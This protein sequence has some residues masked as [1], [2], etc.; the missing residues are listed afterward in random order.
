MKRERISLKSLPKKMQ[1]LSIINYTLSG[2]FCLASIAL[3]IYYLIIGDPNNRFISCLL[4][5]VLFVLPPLAE[6]IFKF[7]LVSGV[8]L[9][10]LIFVVLSAFFGSCLDIFASVDFYDKML[11]FSWGY[12]ACLAGLYFLCITKEIDRMKAVMIVVVIFAL[13]MASDSIWEL[14]EFAG[15]SIFGQTA[16]GEA[17]NGI[18][19][20]KD[21]MLDILVHLLGTILFVVQYSIDRFMEVKLGLNKIIDN[22]KHQSQLIGKTK[23]TA[24]IE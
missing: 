9:I 21:T 24:N 1:V 14:I 16:Q 8:Y 6:Y 19:S 15:D 17:I 3:L 20:V 10:Y 13:S 22:F 5:S 2:I 23:N 11:H 18:V 4:T 7:R 12:L